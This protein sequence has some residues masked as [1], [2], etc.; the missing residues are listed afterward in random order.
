MPW[1]GKSFDAE[2]SE[3][4][5]VL[6]PSAKTPV[7]ILWPSYQPENETP[8]GLEVFPFRNRV[9][10][11]AVDP[12]LD[13]LKIDYDFEANPN[14]IIRRILDELVEVAEGLYLGKI[15]YR[16]RGNFRPI[17]FFSLERD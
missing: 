3:G 7:K 9:A 15:L 6:I 17:G 16:H 14:F 12:E 13:V 4:F 8:E 11:G 1:Q 5:N 2:R 10:P